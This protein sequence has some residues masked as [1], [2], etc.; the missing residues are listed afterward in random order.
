MAY[1]AIR[2]PH[3][4]ENAVI[5]GENAGDAVLTYDEL[6][7][8]K[9]IQAKIIEEEYEGNINDYIGVL[10]VEYEVTEIDRAMILETVER[11]KFSAPAIS[12]GFIFAASCA[13]TIIPRSKSLSSLRSPENSDNC[14]MFIYKKRCCDK[15]RVSMEDRSTIRDLV[16]WG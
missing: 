9:E 6:I 13:P 10:L 7:S 3:S 14:D 8:N 2:E 12:K 16:I 5:N 15:V 1:F 11:L 4:G